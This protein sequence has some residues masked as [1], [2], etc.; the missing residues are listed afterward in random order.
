MNLSD[1]RYFYVVDE[2]LQKTT[3]SEFETH[4]LIK[5]IFLLDNLSALIS[6]VLSLLNTRQNSWLFWNW[7]GLELIV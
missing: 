5:T 2:D 1:G 4:L 3:E 7:A 6:S